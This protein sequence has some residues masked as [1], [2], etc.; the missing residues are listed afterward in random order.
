M[1]EKWLAIDTPTGALALDDIS[2]FETVIV[3]TVVI[4]LISVD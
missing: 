2:K 4:L 1:I 3:L